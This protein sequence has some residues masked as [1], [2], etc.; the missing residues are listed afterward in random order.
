MEANLVSV[1][2]PVYNGESFLEDCLRS[3]LAQTYTDFEYIV[4]DNCSTDRTGEIA[5]DYASRDERVRVIR[6]TE[7]RDI[8]AN[9]NYSL[10]H[11]SD[12]SAYCK[13]VCADDWLYPECLEAMVEVGKEHPR[14][15]VIG[16]YRLFGPWVNLDGIPCEGPPQ[17][18]LPVSVVS[19]REIC[20]A[21]LRGGPYVFGSNSSVL[22]RAELVRTQEPFYDPG[23]LHA[24][25]LAC[26]AI[27]Q[28]W[29]FGFIHQ[30]LTCTRRHAASATDTL[31]KPLNT[32]LPA[33]IYRLQRFG[34]VFLD[35]KEAEELLE[36]AI[37][38]YFSFLHKATAAGADSGFWD[39]HERELS[40]L[41]LAHRWTQAGRVE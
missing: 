34:P 28:E 33:K 9:W 12:R 39:Y 17:G 35:P 27:L 14:V 3:V 21:T 18:R 25:S 2:T 22:V 41:G 20:A 6:S 32:K 40:A 23:T 11:I 16:A 36:A 37:H 24:D 30:V 31:A 10:T 26:Y 15:G 4:V 1:V 7:H 29:D 5:Q 13:V 38:R 19:G 8:I